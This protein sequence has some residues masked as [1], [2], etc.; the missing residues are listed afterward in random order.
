M[1]ANFLRY[2]PAVKRFGEEVGHACFQQLVSLIL[3]GA[4]ESNHRDLFRAGLSSEH[5]TEFGRVE[6]GRVELDHNYI[7]F[8]T[9]RRRSG[10][11]SRRS[12]LDLV[13][14]A[15]LDRLSRHSGQFGIGFYQDHAALVLFQL[16]GNRHAISLEEFDKVGTLNTTMATGGAE[17]L[18]LL[19]VNPGCN[20]RKSH[21]ANSTDVMSLIHF[22]CTHAYLLR[23]FA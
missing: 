22:L 4:A 12:Y 3:G 6:A 18:Y 5:A 16:G 14:P 19:L 11:D 20:S 7:R 13:F 2:L 21:A 17:P 1:A 8:P 15:L 9:R 23:S 10:A